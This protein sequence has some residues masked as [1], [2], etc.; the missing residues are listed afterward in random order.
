MKTARTAV[1]GFAR[2]AQ[3]GAERVARSAKI[4][5]TGAKNIA[6]SAKVEENQS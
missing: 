5:Q 6:R 2:S 3:K 1:K 4:A